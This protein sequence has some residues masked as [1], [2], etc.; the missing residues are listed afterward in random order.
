MNTCSARAD[1]RM[2]VVDSGWMCSPGGRGV[3]GGRFEQAAPR[4]W[5]GAVDCVLDQE[6][7]RALLSMES[8]RQDNIRKIMDAVT[9]AATT[10][11]L[12]EPQ[13]SRELLDH[14][15]FRWFRPIQAAAD[16]KGTD[17]HGRSTGPSIPRESSAHTLGARG[18]PQPS[19]SSSR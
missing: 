5:D 4:S 11:R 12:Q 16:N 8:R 10:R 9:C 18:V 3:R 15:T 13:K 2:C 7:L 14:F 1:S 6:P 17:L 19:V